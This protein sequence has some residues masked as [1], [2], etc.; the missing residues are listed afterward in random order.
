MDEPV[1]VTT[2]GPSAT[3]DTV[4]SMPRVLTGLGCT[5]CGGALEVDEGVTN[6][7]CGYCGTPVAVVGER[8]IARRMVRERI[9]RQAALAS[10]RRWFA[11]GVRKEPALRRQAKIVETF[12][13]WFPFVRV[14][15]DV[16]GWVLGY[17]TGRRKRGNRWVEDRKPEERQIERSFD[18]TSPA[19]EMAEFGVERIDLSGDRVE[20]LDLDLL[21][22]RGMVFR[23]VLAPSEEADRAER[24]AVE[25]AA[26]A[27]APDRVTY[28]WLAPLGRRVT[29]VYYPLWVVRFGFR[30]R[31]YQ[32]L[33][34]AEDG[35]I[36]WGKAPGNHTFRAASLIA[37]CAATCFVATTV[38]QHLD[39]V[40]R[41]EGGLGA[42]GALGL[43]L[44]AAVR[45]GY[46]Q[47]RHGGVVE[48]GTGVPAA[49]RWRSLGDS[50]KQ[51]VGSR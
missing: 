26:S 37:A 32:V 3:S 46:S 25:E 44:L 13:A 45:W 33:V 28:R 11:S 7:V 2:V 16:V 38:L 27:A 47:F 12:L 6:V 17:S 34:D 31:F 36:A 29:L 19:A 35:R 10:V 21:R 48:E 30:N 41:G 22:A 9:D 20:P 24:V 43:A 49:R 50:L 14:E 4:A 18:W 51:V 40:F 23:P 39:W 8:G 1:G 5:S 42:L 15:V